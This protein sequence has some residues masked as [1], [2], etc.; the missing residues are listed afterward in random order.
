VR[1]GAKSRVSGLQRSSSAARCIPHPPELRVGVTLRRLYAH[2][3]PDAR[4]LH[5]LPY[6]SRAYDIIPYCTALTL[7]LPRWTRI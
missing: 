1:Y 2:D 3:I 4:S 6:L 7:A 5:S